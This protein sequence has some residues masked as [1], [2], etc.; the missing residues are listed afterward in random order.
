MWV[1][2]AGQQLGTQRL[3]QTVDEVLD[4]SGF[5]PSKLG[6]EVTER[7]LVG[8]SMPFGKTSRTP[9]ARCPASRR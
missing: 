5:S 6:L 1:N 8:R 2:I 3:T 4:C 9:A 7:Q